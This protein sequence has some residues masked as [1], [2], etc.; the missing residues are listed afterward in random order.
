[1]PTSGLLTARVSPFSERVILP[2]SG[3][4]RFTE[5]LGRQFVSD[6]RAGAAGSI[7]AEVAARAAP[8]GYTLF[9][10]PASIAISQ[11]L[12]RK[13]MALARVKPGELAFAPAHP[14]D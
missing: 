13:L 11:T 9:M 12:Y 4:H 5:A 3:N 1:M 14:S 6:N 2:E 7:G 8:D 10:A